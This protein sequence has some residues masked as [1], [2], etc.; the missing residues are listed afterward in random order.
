MTRWMF[1]DEGFGTLDGASLE[2]A[3]GTLSALQQDAGQD[4]SRS[5][6][7]SKISR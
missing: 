7:T 1:L 4:R 3:P 5:W 2:M 6:P